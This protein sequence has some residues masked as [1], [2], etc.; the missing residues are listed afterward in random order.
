MRSCKPI[1][2]EFTSI[3]VKGDLNYLRYSIFN[4]I[5]RLLELIMN[6][7][8]NV[9]DTKAIFYED[10][11]EDPMPLRQKILKDFKMIEILTDLIYLCS[12]QLSNKDL[13]P[14]SQFWIDRVSSSPVSSRSFLS[15]FEV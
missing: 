2:Q 8:F 5:M 3:L 12:H 1:L 4:D 7:L 11:R 6:F 9:S 14:S 10:Y 15:C 13:S